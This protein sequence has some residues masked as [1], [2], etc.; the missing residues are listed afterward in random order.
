MGM[1]DVVTCVTSSS[2]IA[3]LECVSWRRKKKKKAKKR[4]EIKAELNLNIKYMSRAQKC[5]RMGR[6]ISF[7]T[8]QLSNAF[9]SQEN[10]QFELEWMLCVFVRW[11]MAAQMQ[12]PGAV[13]FQPVA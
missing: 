10:L 8:F 12:R 1:S 7:N 4:F 13:A 3:Q 11:L 5:R 2:T 6:R 9:D